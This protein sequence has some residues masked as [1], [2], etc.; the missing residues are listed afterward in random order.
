MFDIKK[1]LDTLYG[2]LA[3][4]AA[5][6]IEQLVS[7]YTSRIEQT[8]SEPRWSEEDI[9]LITYADQI[10]SD[11]LTPLRAQNQFLLDQGI[12]ELVSTVHLL[13]FYPWSSDDGF[14]VIDYLEVDP[15][16]GSWD[17][18]AEVAKNFSLMYDLV[19]NHISQ[20][21]AWFQGFLQ[22]ETPYSEYFHTVTADVDLST[23][24]RPRS[25]PLLHE[26]QTSD[27]IANV[28]T[29]F[30]RDQVD[31]NF[32][33]PKVLVE[34]L[35]VLLEYVYR[36]ATIIR[37]DAIAYLWKE[38]GTSCIHLPQTHLIVKLMRAVLDVV[39]PHVILLTETNVPH[40]ENVSYFG[41][42]DEAHMVY[43][44]SLPPLLL[45]ALIS[46]DASILI[47]WLQNLEPTTLNTTYFNFTASHDGVGVRPLEGIVPA[48][49]LS[50]LIEAIQK[51]GG[52]ISTKRNAD[53]TDSPYELNISY[54]DALGD[55]DS[56]DSDLHVRRFLTSQA[57]QLSVAGIPGIYFHSLVG[58]PNDHQGVAESGIPRR[59]NRRKYKR[60][61]LDE[62]LNNEQSL[63]AAV[64]AGYKQLLKIRKQ[65]PAF[66]PNCQQS[67]IDTECNQVV[68][69]QRKTQ[70]ESQRNQEITV[71]ANVSNDSQLLSCESLGISSVQTDLLSEKTFQ[72]EI[73]LEP[74]QTV[75]L[76]DHMQ[77]DTCTSE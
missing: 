42:G 27:G 12:D 65:Q 76:T 39:A 34:V 36:G 46:Q 33:N 1:A 44:F 25:L 67:V 71:L 17:C 59:I 22:G 53:G 51:R 15:N 10:S 21:S 2:S 62:V 57:I 69:F 52:H 32:A 74:F 13:P 60:H 20:E 66:S 16:S 49:R 26:F 61:Q 45:D 48:E 41:E 3:A 4:E 38:I 54:F 43:Q 68:G 7:E 37:L 30:S 5:V 73:S 24:T 55:P 14:S 47:T 9:V 31:L 6:A 64:L 77:N 23:V 35:T 8:R 56:S 19:C 28:W 11:S 63:Q 50:S 58:T 29:T 70:H 72:N 18:I 40:S 75:W